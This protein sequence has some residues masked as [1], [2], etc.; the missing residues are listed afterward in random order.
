MS[1]NLPLSQSP[2]QKNDK[3]PADGKKNPVDCPIVQAVSP[4]GPAEDGH[5]RQLKCQKRSCIKDLHLHIA[6]NSSIQSKRAAL[7]SCTPVLDKS[8]EARSEQLHISLA[9][10]RSSV[11]SLSDMAPVEAPNYR[12]RILE[13]NNIHILSREDAIPESQTELAQRMC[14]D[15]RASP[16]PR[17]DEVAQDSE[18]NGFF[19]RATEPT[20]TRMFLSKFASGVGATDTQALQLS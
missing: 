10:D 4:L 8:S 7:D 13:P 18:L 9:S 3:K 14:G 16:E 19:N 5:E 12:W 15:A 20:V 17:P 6:P 1:S 11:C 2:L